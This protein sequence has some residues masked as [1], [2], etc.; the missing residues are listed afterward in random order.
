[1]RLVQKIAEMHDGTVEARSEGI[2]KGSE[3]IVQL[4]MGI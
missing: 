1:M 4:P 2:G 3:V